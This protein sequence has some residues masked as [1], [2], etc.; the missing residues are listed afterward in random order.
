VTTM[1]GG[2]LIL[3]ARMLGQFLA[4]FSLF[5]VFGFSMMA[6]WRLGSRITRRH[7]GTDEPN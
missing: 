3:S 2:P 1:T 5:V 6:A 4:V 7:R